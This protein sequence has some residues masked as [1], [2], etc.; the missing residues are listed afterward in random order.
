MTDDPLMDYNEQIRAPK[1][2]QRYSVG[3]IGTLK[4]KEKDKRDVADK[5]ASKSKFGDLIN[6]KM[7]S[8]ADRNGKKYQ[9]AEVDVSRIKSAV[10]VAGAAASTADPD[11]LLYNIDDFLQ[12][13]NFNRANNV[14]GNLNVEYTHTDNSSGGSGTNTSAT[15]TANSTASPTANTSPLSSKKGSDESINYNFIESTKQPRF[16]MVPIKPLDEPKTLDY[17]PC[18]LRP[19]ITNTKNEFGETI[20]TSTSTLTRT[21]SLLDDQSDITYKSHWKPNSSTAHCLDCAKSFS[22]MNRRHHCRKCGEIFCSNCLLFKAKLK[23]DEDKEITEFDPINGITCKVCFQCG[24]NWGTFIF[25]GLKNAETQSTSAAVAGAAAS[26]T[27]GAGAGA[28]SPWL[29]PNF[30]NV[31]NSARA[32]GSTTTT[33][34]EF[35]KDNAPGSSS[36]NGGVMSTGNGNDGAAVP[37]DWTW[38]SF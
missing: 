34:A 7:D 35:S 6:Q 22:L 26:S 12:H 31:G 38:S 36:G 25:Q 9:P 21:T 2:K 3:D 17:L 37:A 23:Y 19:A 4:D 5:K 16:N 29:Y 20:D 32:L 10:V 15:R 27:A 30:K 28:G 13:V 18:V 14:I 1:F 24:K 8:M 11:S 33:A